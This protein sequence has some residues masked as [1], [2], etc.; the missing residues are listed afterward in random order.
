MNHLGPYALGPNAE[1]QGV[2]TG[3]AR[4]LA[5]AIPDES[6]D[7]IFTDPPYAKEFRHLYGELAELAARVLVPGG[8]LFA[9][10][11]GYWLMDVLDLVRPHLNYHWLCCL[12]HPT[13]T[14]SYRCF[15][16][17]LDNYWKPILWFTKGVYSGPY[18][19]DGINTSVPDKRYHKWGQQ[20]RWASSFIQRFPPET[21]I[22]DPMCGGGT[23]P[24]VCKMLGRRWLAFEIKPDVA[25]RARERIRNTQPPLPGLVVPQQ[26]K[27]AL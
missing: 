23:V 4:E 7:L 27:L 2:Y 22:F 18:M 12:Y 8:S 5:K 24:A 26:K 11:G 16:R 25:E 1:N 14:Q 3:D 19:A 20:V 9:L 17:R 6:V 15:P 10:S 21:A 13:V